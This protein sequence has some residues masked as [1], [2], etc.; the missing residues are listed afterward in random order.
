M[1]HGNQ[2]EF[3]VHDD[4]PG[5]AQDYHDQIFRMFT[6]LKPRDAVEGSG[7][8]L[9]LVKKIVEGRGGAIQLESAEGRGAT[10]RFTWPR[11]AE[12]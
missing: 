10:F 7:M 3:I 4:G 8:G 1:D 5:I 11:S 6:T 9:A 12:G 2:I